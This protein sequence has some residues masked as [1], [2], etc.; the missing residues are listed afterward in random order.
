[1]KRRLGINEKQ[2]GKVLARNFV[3][4]KV[5]YYTTYSTIL[6]FYIRMWSCPDDKKKLEE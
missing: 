1:M 3:Y 2:G 6:K 5:K 4:K